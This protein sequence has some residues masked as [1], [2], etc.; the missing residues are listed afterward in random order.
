MTTN[1]PFKTRA[2]LQ[3]QNHQK[4]R[5]LHRGQTAILLGNGP[6]LDSWHEEL[7]TLSEHYLTIGINRSWMRSDS[8][9]GFCAPY[10]VI[11]GEMHGVELVLG[12]YEPE[13]VFTNK[14]CLKSMSGYG[15]KVFAVDNRGDWR[16]D[17]FVYNIDRGT[18]APFAGI[19]A[20][21]VAA[22]L[23]CTEMFLIGYDMGLK[24]HHYNPDSDGFDRSKHV[25]HFNG[26]AKWASA[27]GVEIW[28][29]N[30]ESNVDQFPYGVPT[31]AKR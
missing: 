30:P 28:N 13:V 20:I 24:P 9:P 6:S 23:G 4:Y 19:F 8:T 17:Q 11:F 2:R 31:L 29:A 5:N 7:P 26:V 21:Q 16:P 18:S 25:H 27:A 10:H 12:R 22:W 1:V 3:F 15:G 14:S